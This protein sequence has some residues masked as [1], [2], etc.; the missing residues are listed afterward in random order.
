[1]QRQGAAG[2]EAGVSDGMPSACVTMSACKRTCTPQG[3]GSIAARL[4]TVCACQRRRVLQGWR[5]AKGSSL[6][7]RRNNAT[8]GGSPLGGYAAQIPFAHVAIYEM[9]SN[10]RTCRLTHHIAAK[11]AL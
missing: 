8:P 5:D 10:I 6:C 1:M 11:N 2:S 9:T 7:E 4:Q 3:S